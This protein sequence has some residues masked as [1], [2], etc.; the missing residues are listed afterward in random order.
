[1]EHHIQSTL[2]ISY[3]QFLKRYGGCGFVG[4]AAI[5]DSE[6]ELLI[7]TL[8]RYEEICK[9]LDIHGDLRDAGKLPIGDDMAGNLFV[10]DA[11][12]EAIFFLDFSRNPPLGILVASSFDRFLDMIDVTP[13]E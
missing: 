5:R 3:R 10:L 2:P 1:V 13:F 7:F 4:D 11:E 12:T 8:F 9:M 6:S